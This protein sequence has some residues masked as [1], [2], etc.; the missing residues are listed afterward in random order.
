VPDPPGQQPAIP[1]GLLQ[2]HP[3]G[4]A[5]VGVAVVGVAVVGVAVVGVA[6]VAGADVGA[7]QEGPD[8]PLLTQFTFVPDPS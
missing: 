8:A 5:V 3:A 1:Q 7:E 4:A 6:V 2:V